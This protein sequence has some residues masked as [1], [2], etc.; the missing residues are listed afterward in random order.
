VKELDRGP[1]SRLTFDDGQDRRP[2]WSRDGTRILFISDRGGREDLWAQPAD[3]TGAPELVLHLAKPILEMQQTPDE[4]QFVLRLGGVANAT[5]MRDLVS[6]QR[7]DTVTKPVAAEPYDEK[8][9]SMSPDGR[10]VA[11]ESTETGRNEIYVRPF[12]DVNGG[13]WQVSTGGGINPRW[14]HD[15]R[16]L[17]YV[18]GASVMTAAQVETAGS[19][20]VASRTP[21]FSLNERQIYAQANYAAY[22]VAPDGRRFVMVQFAQPDTD[23]PRDLIVVE[24]FFRELR[25]KAGR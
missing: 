23:Q 22:D 5:G 6:L 12:P 3:G 4:Q 14:S 11:Y 10:W 7:G 20:R 2:R 16:E 13:K 1:L 21:L 8:A 17:F 15:G 9:V 24:N 19:F 18:D 25:E